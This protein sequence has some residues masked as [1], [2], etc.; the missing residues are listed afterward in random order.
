MRL[1]GGRTGKRAVIAE[2]LE[3]TGLTDP[4]DPEIDYG[5]R[6]AVLG[7][8]GT[9]KSH[10]LRLLAG[11]RRSTTRSWRLGAPSSPGLL[12]PDP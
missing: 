5:E 12:L 2:Q 9:G 11:G 4:F 6:V 1:G 8:N 7:P 3:L 10:L